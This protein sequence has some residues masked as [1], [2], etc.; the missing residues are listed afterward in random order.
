M[1]LLNTGKVEARLKPTELKLLRDVANV[2]NNINQIAK[3][4][5]SLET[6]RITIAMAEEAIG[7]IHLILDNVQ[8]SKTKL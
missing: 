8:N 6:D 3:K 5:N 4:L 1:R 2:G 7:K